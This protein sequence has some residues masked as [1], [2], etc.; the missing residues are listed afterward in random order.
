M[1]DMIK[2]HERPSAPYTSFRYT[3]GPTMHVASLGIL[4]HNVFWCCI[5][6]AQPDEACDEWCVV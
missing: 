5:S 4:I 6:Q 1:L 2:P 3:E